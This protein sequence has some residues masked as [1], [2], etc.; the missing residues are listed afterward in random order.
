[1][2]KIVGIRQQR[3]QFFYDTL[4]RN[5][6]SLTTAIG[7]SVSLFSAATPGDLARTNLQIAGQLASDQTFLTYAIRH[8]LYLRPTGTTNSAGSNGVAGAATDLDTR[9]AGLFRDLIHHSTFQFKVDSKVEF[10]GMWA[11]T[12]AGGGTY[13]YLAD[14]VDVNFVNGEPSARSI[15]VLPLPIAVTQRQ[16][17]AVIEQ[18]SDIPTGG[19][20]GAAAVLL[21]TNLNQ[22]QGVKIGRAYIDGY[23]SREVS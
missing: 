4:F 12:P 5:R 3:V 13:G 2:A 14:S 23:H 9:S 17:I 1:M 11:M 16:A 6:G 10:E 20:T 21:L 18:I 19:G 7:T 8:E 22:F 15:Y